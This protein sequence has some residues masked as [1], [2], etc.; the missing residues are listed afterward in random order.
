MKSCFFG[1]IYAIFFEKKWYMLWLKGIFLY[2][3][4]VLKIFLN[5]RLSLIVPLISQVW[6]TSSKLLCKELWRMNTANVKSTQGI[7]TKFMHWITGSNC[8]GHCITTHYL[9]SAM[10]HQFTFWLFK[11]C[12][13]GPLLIHVSPCFRE[14]VVVTCKIGSFLCSLDIVLQK[15]VIVFFFG[16]QI[17]KWHSFAKRAI[18]DLLFTFFSYQGKLQKFLQH[19]S[20]SHTYMYFAHPIDSFCLTN[21]EKKYE[22]IRYGCSLVWFLVLILIHAILEPSINNKMV[23]KI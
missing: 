7:H 14:I 15:N 9:P 23:G 21:F 18:F 8:C 11:E 22:F 2:F 12:G 13:M 6:W 16:S 10:I 19:I 3:W 17:S 5:P 20:H 4:R 1:Q